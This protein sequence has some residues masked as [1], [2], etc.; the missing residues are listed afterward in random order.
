ML[1]QEEIIYISPKL[2]PLADSGELVYPLA[3]YGSVSLTDL[4]QMMGSN[5]TILLNATQNPPVRYML[6]RSSNLTDVATKTRGVSRLPGVKSVIVDLNREI[7]V[8]TSFMHSLVRENIPDD[9]D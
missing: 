7:F 8:N 5:D 3:V 9:N 1:T 4:Y 6:C 2:G